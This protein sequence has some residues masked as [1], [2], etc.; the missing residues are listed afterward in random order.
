VIG[1]SA[2]KDALAR[3]IAEEE[4]SLRQLQREEAEAAAPL[5]RKTVVCSFLL[6]ALSVRATGAGG[7]AAD[8]PVLSALRGVDPKIRKTTTY[9]RIEAA[10]F[11]LLL[12]A[13]TAGDQIYELQSREFWWDPSSILVLLKKAPT[14]REPEVLS[15]VRQFVPMGSTVRIL[16]AKPDEILLARPYDDE[17]ASAPHL[18]FFIDI[19]RSTARTVEF[20]PFTFQTIRFDGR[21]PQFVVGDG[22]R[23]LVLRA[24]S[25][26]PFLKLLSES[27]AAPI[28]S[29][30]PIGVETVG[31]KEIRTVDSPRR[32]VE[33]GTD[34]QFRWDPRDSSKV[35]EKTGSDEKAFPLP[36]SSQEDWVKAR[37]YAAGKTENRSPADSGFSCP[38]CLPEE[39]IGPSQMVGPL[40][41]FGKS[42]IDGE[43]S[44][45]IG[46]VG[47]FDT[48]SRKFMMLRIP[49]AE[50]YS[51][52][53][54]LV[55]GNTLWIG[56]A[57]N[58]SCSSDMS[59]GLLR[60]DLPSGKTRR[61]ELPAIASSIVRFEDRLY[62]GTSD[63]VTII[64]Q[65]GEPE[66]YFVDKAEDG[67]LKLA[68]SDF[69][70]AAAAGTTSP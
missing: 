37:P 32:P 65:T 48:T 54:L 66:L 44:T 18:K 64:P 57:Y 7:T 43:G 15:V 17:G 3:A 70:A 4:A 38:S 30:L 20:E 47:Y 11:D 26:A 2:K 53:A 51:A 49:E 45:G 1:K 6:L 31:G 56:Q 63:G 40:L 28:V 42:F 59:G 23:F 62:V 67:S 46:G 13:A 33:F 24:T 19:R 34:G 69:R 25:T 22:Q 21:V 35:F 60:V 58:S 14:E 27:D 52:S 36:Q 55:E 9:A 12:V 61:Y 39:H 5:M 68:K 8:D 50:E 29:A 10:D 41:W 16:R